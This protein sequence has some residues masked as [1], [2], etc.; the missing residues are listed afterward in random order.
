MRGQASDVIIEYSNVKV[1]Q[2]AVPVGTSDGALMF[3][4]C[5]MLS[6]QIPPGASDFKWWIQ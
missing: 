6:F 2:H 3:C 5:M 1:R 4:D